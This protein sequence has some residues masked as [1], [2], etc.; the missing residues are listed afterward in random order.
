MKTTEER[1]FIMVEVE[2]LVK[3]WLGFVGSTNECA[4]TD[5]IIEQIQ[6][7]VGEL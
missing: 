4:Y 1:I 5:R 6:A 3:E 2:N 7:K